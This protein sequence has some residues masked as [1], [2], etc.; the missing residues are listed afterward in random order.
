VGIRAT[1][2][3]YPFLSE[4]HNNLC[5]YVTDVALYFHDVMQMTSHL[6]FIAWMQQLLK[7]HILLS[8]IQ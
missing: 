2:V 6:K 1:M 7:C 3:V 4:D 8:I 5:W